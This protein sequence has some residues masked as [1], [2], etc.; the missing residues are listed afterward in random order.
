MATNEL[1]T[2]TI[3]K[4]RNRINSI[5]FKLNKRLQVNSPL[6][7]RDPASENL[8]SYDR[9]LKRRKLEISRANKKKNEKSTYFTW[10]RKSF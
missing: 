8:N 1:L 6:T 7:I 2:V 4:Q 5:H 3:K 9:C 10:L